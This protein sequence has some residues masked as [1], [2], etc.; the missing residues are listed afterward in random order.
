MFTCQWNFG[1]ELKSNLGTL[2]GIF[3]ITLCMQC[4]SRNAPV[5][6]EVEEGCEG[7][8]GVVAHVLELCDELLA[9]LVVDHGDLERRRHVG[10]EVAVVG[11]LKVQ[12]QICK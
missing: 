10:Q 2:L 8:R 5:R 12:F 9:Q 3:G 11:R 4:L 6:D 1:W 7:A